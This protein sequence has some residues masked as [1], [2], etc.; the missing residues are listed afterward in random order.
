MI[1]DPPAPG[2]P[3]PGPEPPA[4]EPAA[5]N[6]Q[7]GLRRVVS[8]QRPRADLGEHVRTLTIR[9]RVLRSLCG[10]GTRKRT[11]AGLH[12]ESRWPTGAE[13]PKADGRKRVS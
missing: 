13:R 2:P 9:G 6:R 8:G 1:I 5:A 12:E 3:A 4:P 10:R 11:V 7:S